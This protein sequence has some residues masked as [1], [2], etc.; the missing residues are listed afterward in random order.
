MNQHRSYENEYISVGIENLKAQNTHLYLW[1]KKLQCHLSR[2]TD[3]SRVDI[4]I[5]KIPRTRVSNFVKQMCLLYSLILSDLR[6][7]FFLYW[8]R[9]FSICVFLRFFV[10]LSFGQ[11]GLFLSLFELLL[12][13]VDVL[14]TD[15]DE[16]DPVDDVQV[17]LLSML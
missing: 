4:V 16:E 11:I 9:L 2:L 13:T 14:L 15:L 5:G 17:V 8:G 3:A 6:I 12:H 1:L 7:F 10:D